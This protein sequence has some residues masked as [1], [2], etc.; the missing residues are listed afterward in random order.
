MIRTILVPLDGSPFGEQALPLALSIA[1]RSQGIVHLLHVEPSR[2]EDPYFDRPAFVTKLQEE[3]LASL[4]SRLQRTTPVAF[5]SRVQ[6]GE[7]AP[8]IAATAE[9]LAA[10]L[11]V[12]TTHGRGALQRLWLGSV[13]DELIRNYSHRVLLV[14]PIEGEAGKSAEPTIQRLLLPLDG[15]ELAEQMIEPAVDLGSLMAVDYTLL[16]LVVPVLASLTLIDAG[17]LGEQTRAFMEQSNA[18]TEQRAQEAGAYLERV[19]Q[20]LRSRS[21]SV[22][23]K[24]VVHPEPA[25]AILEAAQAG[26]DLIAIQTHGRRGLSRLVMGSVADKVIRGANVPVLVQRPA[27]R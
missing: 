2:S 25:A 6:N 1:R 27:K 13:A 9:G 15:T 20:G 10:D 12:M 5:T 7:I 16:R 8:T 18:L 23:T 26:T 14:R 22:Q 17:T 4:V 19:A 21:L 11:I 3:Y 24:V